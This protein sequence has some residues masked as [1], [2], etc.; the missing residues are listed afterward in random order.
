MTGSNRLAVLAADIQAAHRDATQGA[1]AVAERALA[2]GRMLEEAKAALPHGKW[3]TWLAESVGMSARTARRYMQ[4][5]RA[6]LET[7]TVAD[8][9]IR[10]A[11][12]RLV[13]TTRQPTRDVDVEPDYLTWRDE[14]NAELAKAPS[15]AARDQ[16]I[17]SLRE[18][19]E[20]ERFA[21]LLREMMD[22]S[23]LDTVCRWIDRT[24]PRQVAKILRANVKKPV[25]INEGKV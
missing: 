13:R 11:A 20:V 21:A 19:V 17:Q 2:A 1:L 18:Q 6:G 9:G 10:G 22:P 25:R 4:I 3:A 7:A 15:P 16:A 12:E 23:E 5:S 14:M 8:L 24:D